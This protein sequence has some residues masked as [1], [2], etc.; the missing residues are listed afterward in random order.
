MPT[1]ALVDALTEE[2]QLSLM[3]VEQDRGEG[4]TKSWDYKEQF[5]LAVC[6]F[7]LFS[8]CWNKDLIVAALEAEEVE[9]EI[10]VG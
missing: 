10:I 8:L 2:S 5:L 7:Y 1:P 9:L 3:T 4:K 6:N